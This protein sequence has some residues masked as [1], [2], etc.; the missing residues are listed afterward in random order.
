[1]ARVK[2]G[3][4]LD[5]VVF[6]SG[7]GGRL[8]GSEEEVLKGAIV[9]AVD[10]IT[11]TGQIMWVNMTKVPDDSRRYRHRKLLAGGGGSDKAKCTFAA[12]IMV[13]SLGFEDADDVLS[14]L[15]TG[16][17]ASIQGGNLERA[18]TTR[19]AAA[20]GA[21]AAALANAAVDVTLSVDVV[22]TETEVD[23]IE[24][25]FAPPEAPPEGQDAGDAPLFGIGVPGVAG[26]GAA[27]F[28]FLVV[29]VSSLHDR[30]HH[31]N[32]PIEPEK[33]NKGPASAATAGKKYKVDVMRTDEPPLFEYDLGGFGDA[34]A[35][36]VM[37]P[38]MPEISGG[39]PVSTLREGWEAHRSSNQLAPLNVSGSPSEPQH[40][41]LI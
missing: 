13:E 36:P 27:V 12:D 21:A 30:R 40:E 14:A 20:G 32:E 41:S 17:K 1:M 31:K 33:P 10:V 9:D 37:L 3:F 19:A 7:N 38:R 11:R 25:S 24:V 26:I 34:P 18:V 28:A 8:S 4:V 29:V 15:A 22:D 39:H 5:G 6:S 2:S 35:T 23:A 16:L